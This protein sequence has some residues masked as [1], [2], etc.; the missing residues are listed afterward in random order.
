MV[1]ET[2]LLDRDDDVAVAQGVF[3][4]EAGE[5]VGCKESPD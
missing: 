5:V 4:D 3:A 2:K 1:E